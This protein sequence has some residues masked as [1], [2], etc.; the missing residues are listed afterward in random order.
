MTVTAAAAFF[1]VAAG[2]PAVEYLPAPAIN[3]TPAPF[4]SAVR[5]GDTLYLAGAIGIGADG[6]LPEGIEAQSKQTMD[7]IGAVLKRA[8]LGFDDVYKCT[9][10]LADMK[11]WPAFNGV[12]VT[13][14]KPDRRPSRS[15]LGVNGL[16]LGALLEVECQAYAGKK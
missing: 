15:A 6:K 9:A 2:Q 7:N 8:G 11:D 13:Y 4:S 14:F 10:F 16:A 5:V 12:Y 3:N 1:L